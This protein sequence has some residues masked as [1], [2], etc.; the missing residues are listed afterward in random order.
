MT[1]LNQ[2]E[3]D[4]LDPRVNIERLE[5]LLS[6]LPD[7]LREL[8]LHGFLL[9]PDPALA[10]AIGSTSPILDRLNARVMEHPMDASDATVA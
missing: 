1:T 10:A 6:K 3:R 8:T 2:T 7:E 4:R 5:E 9:E